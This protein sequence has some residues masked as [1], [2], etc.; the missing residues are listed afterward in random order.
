MFRFR[1]IV[2]SSLT[3]AALAVTAIAGDE[4]DTGLGDGTTIIEGD[5]HG[6]GIEVQQTGPM[7]TATL[8][9]DGSQVQYDTKIITRPFCGSD[10]DAVTVDDLLL[11]AEQHAQIF[12]QTAN[13]PPTGARPRAGFDL[14]FNIGG[15]PP[16]GATAAI[17]A[18]ETYLE[19]LFDD[20]VTVTIS[21]DFQSLPSGILGW[22][23]SARVSNVAWTTA[24][25]GLIDGMDAD[26]WI[27]NH[28]PLVATNRIPVRYDGNSGAVTNESVVD[29][30]VATYNAGIGSTGGT[31]ASMSIS[32]NFSWDY[33]PSNGVSSGTYCFRSVLAHEVGHALGFVS[34]ADNTSGGQ[35]ELLDIYRFQRTDGGGDYNP[36]DVTDFETQARL[37]DYNTPNND[38]SMAFYLS[39]GTE[40]EY[41]MSD[42]DPYQASH[43]GQG[44][45]NA[46]MQPA[47][48]AGVTFYPNYYRTADVD[49]FDLIGW[50]YAPEPGTTTIPF[51]DAFL[52]TLLDT[53]LWT[54]IVGAESKVAMDAPSV[55]Y[56]MNLA[57]RSTGGESART[58]RMNTTP[59]ADVVITYAWQR[60]GNENSP[61]SG[62]DLV[63]EYYNA[64]H[65]WVE[66]AR[67]LGSGSDMTTF[68]TN[69]ITLTLAGDPDAFHTNFRLQFRN[70]SL[71][72]ESDDYFVDNVSVSTTTDFTPPMPNPM[73]WESLPAPVAGSLN[74]ITMTCSVATDPSGVQY[75][76]STGA[77]AVLSTWTTNRTFVKGGLSTNFPYSFA[78]KARDNATPTNN[79][80][81]SSA[82]HWTATNIQTPTGITFANVAETEMD[83]TASGSFTNLSYASSGLYFEMSPAAGTGANVWTSSTTNKTI[84][85]SGLTPGQT[86]TFR[87]KARNAYAIETPYTTT[88]EQATVSAGCTLFG[89]INEDSLVNGEDVAGFTRAKI[90]QSPEPGENPA[91]AEN[92]GTTEQDI[93]DFID[94]LLGS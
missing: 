75:L 25:T 30:N 6:H 74:S 35:M 90:G 70:T 63:V 65:V 38:H 28:L 52:D 67:H 22:T 71:N 24:R 26:D 49:A 91:C 51:Y 82:V 4:P 55:P 10:P 93:A 77:G 57:G 33:D 32:T 73:T 12:A 61:E 92:G 23:S 69:A 84:H 80:T 27:Q 59:L 83:V 1:L 34:A 39:D 50:D 62:E 21:I 76:F 8:Y 40:V 42:G 89:D 36:D 58:A 3:L 37:V 86:Y 94:L 15:S 53:T 79:L 88:F 20:D 47:F 13:E 14:V 16:A 44:A 9:E 66:I 78:V 17:T 81:A 43:F 48:S 46:I 87:V 19:G 64:A 41:Q 56:A 2:L 31:A 18:V 5:A 85:V 45:V 29:V 7:L 54:G 68:E 11:A 72:S 60:T